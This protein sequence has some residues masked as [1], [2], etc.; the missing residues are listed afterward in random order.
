MEHLTEAFRKQHGAHNTPPELADFVAD[1]ILFA[2]KG[3]LKKRKSISIIDPAAG[4]GELLI[5]LINALH[6]SGVS[7]FPI[8][9]FDQDGL[10]LERGRE[11]LARVSNGSPLIARNCDFLE[12]TLASH[13]AQTDLFSD[14]S[15]EATHDLLIANPPYVRTQVLGAAKAQSIA[16]QFGLTGRVDLSYAFVLGMIELL[17]PDGIAGI[18]TSNRFLSTRS[19]NSLR[20]ALLERCKILHIWD[21][22]DT[23][24]FDAAVLP[25]VLLLQKAPSNGSRPLF[26]SI[27]STSSSSTR[28]DPG[29]VVRSLLSDSTGAQ[30][31]GSSTAQYAVRRGTLYTGASAGDT[32]RLESDET[33][34]WLDKVKLNTWKRFSDVGKI[35]V[36][37]K[38]TADSVF[39]RDEWKSC[40]A[41]GL[42]ETLQPLITHHLARRF[43]G[44]PCKKQI[45]YTHQVI[46]GR[47]AP[48]SLEK[49]PRAAAYLERNQEALKSRSY[50]TNSGRQWY[51]IW[52]PQDPQLWACPKIVF[53]DISERPTFWLDT[54]ASI[55]NG[56]CYWLP[57]PD[58]T[59][60]DLMWLI[61][62]VA[63]SRFIEAFYDL[64]FPNKLYS[65]RRRF[66]TQYVELFPI[67]DPKKSA[68]RAIA[69]AARKIHELTGTEDT[70]ALEI[71]LDSLVFDA[72]GVAGEEA[73]R[74]RNL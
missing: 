54:S 57:F 36:G 17:R 10:A 25:C 56:D 5:S 60:E 18:I 4:D 67:P 9:A 66:M 39:I 72:F 70:S 49:N 31:L 46:N 58:K 52:V 59:Q 51:E 45:L 61:L 27:Y 23:K 6:R 69:S 40:C 35:R 26:T 16:Q 73:A 24:F 42:P 28:P 3:L 32:W 12:L 74:Q 21:L 20:S 7:G 43:R 48:I 22:G 38:T 14:S 1:Q 50:V 55:V 65:G 8:H 19:G 15:S 44:H 37:V 2:A 13:T 63:N 33:D 41:S 11:R 47:R 30:T 64:S 34:S 53:K 68:S 62:G 29:A 71:E